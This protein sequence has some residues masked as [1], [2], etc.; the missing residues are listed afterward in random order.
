M[1]KNNKL[2]TFTILV[3]IYCVI[4]VVQNI[5][6]MKTIGTP[7]F[8][9]VGAGT[10]VSWITFLIMDIMSEVYGEKV[11]IKCYTMAGF[12]N[13]FIVLTA[14]MIIALPGSYVQQNEAFYLIFSNGPRTFFASFIAF[15]IGNF[16][17]VKLMCTMK[18]RDNANNRWSFYLRAIVSTVFGQFTDNLLFTSLAFAP[19]G[20]SAFEMAWV[21]I[22]SVV[23]ITSVIEIVIESVFVPVITHPLAKL[24]SIKE[25]I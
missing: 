21:D 17:N 3:T 2:S 4:T 25:D 12:L 24:I 8:A 6:E 22:G 20:L 19:L 11:S 10:L 9:L 1:N 16:I 7:T 15:F 14:Q 5:F 13:M 23:L 18:Q